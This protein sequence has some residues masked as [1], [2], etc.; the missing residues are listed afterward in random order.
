MCVNRPHY[1]FIKLSDGLATYGYKAKDVAT[2]PIL[3]SIVFP[4]LS[5][6]SGLE[7]QLFP[8]NTLIIM[9]YMLMP[10][11]E[12]N[13]TTP[14]ADLDHYYPKMARDSRRHWTMGNTSLTGCVKLS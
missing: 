2:L 11:S 13:G 8:S 3:S 10:P 5:D 9:R 6:F 12:R 14:M 1:R 4:C 7:N